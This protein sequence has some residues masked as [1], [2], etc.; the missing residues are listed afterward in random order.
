M[1]KG[2]TPQS[3]KISDSDSPSAPAASAGEVCIIEADSG[4][5]DLLVELLENQFLVKSFAGLKD[6]EKAFFAKEEQLSP[7]LILCDSKLPDAN[8]LDA[9]RRVRTRDL[10]VPFILLVDQ[11]EPQWTR[12]AFSLGVTDLLEKPFESLLF[13]N[14]F[15]GRIAQSRAARERGRIP[16]LL[17]TQLH[18]TTT[19]ANRLID[20]MNTL[21]KTNTK[22]LHYA[23]SDEDAL[24]FKHANKRE[25]KLLAELEQCRLEYLGLAEKLGKS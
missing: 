2:R 4:L 21:M 7:D 17:E 18:L 8:G 10:A 22:K 25:E 15:H 9:L 3:K 23:S 20:K 13:I 12:E 14:S 5:G 1:E 11:P 24:R 19:H 6:F 16:E